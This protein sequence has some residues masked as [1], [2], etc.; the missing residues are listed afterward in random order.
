MPSSDYP[1]PSVGKLVASW[2]SL[3]ERVVWAL[4][5]KAQGLTEGAS[6]AVKDALLDL[7]SDPPGDGPAD[8]A[9]AQALPPL[10]PDEL[11]AALRGAI[12][13]ALYRAA[14]VINEDACGC[15]TEVTR[16]RVL[17]IFTELAQEV[18]DQALE[19]RVAAAEDDLS[20]AAGG[21]WARRYRR[22]LAAE[23]RWPP[24]EVC[25]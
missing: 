20:S 22:M 23:G 1:N 25:R 16:E 17:A 10:N 8:A 4:A 15:W 3:T 7:G 5:S 19:L 18:L 11:A 21:E 6:D 12:E 2:L 24:R 14:E 13:Y 9:G